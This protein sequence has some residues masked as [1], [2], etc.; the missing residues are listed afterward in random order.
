MKKPSVILSS[1]SVSS[2]IASLVLMYCEDVVSQLSS[3]GVL[4]SELW[5]NINEALY[6]LNA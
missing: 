5:S 1:T 3:C 6:S 4:T 2:V